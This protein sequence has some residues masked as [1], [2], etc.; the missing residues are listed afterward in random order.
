V[1]RAHKRGLLVHPYTF[2]NEQSR[3]APD[4]GG[5]PIKEYLHFY[6]L[7]VDGV[8]SD[9]ADTAFTAR[10]LFRLAHGEGDEE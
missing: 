7:G 10:E 2:R 9:F 8:F 1:Q 4:Y 6:E 3:L 5:N